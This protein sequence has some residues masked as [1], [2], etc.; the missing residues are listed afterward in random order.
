MSALNLFALTP[1]TPDRPVPIEPPPGA[2]D[3]QDVSLPDGI[4]E[5]LRTFEHDRFLFLERHLARAERSM[6]ALGWEE[7]LQE[8]LVRR[9]LQAA[10]SASPQGDARLRLDLFEQPQEVLG[11]TTRALV[12]LAPFRPVS[13]EVLARGVRVGVARGMAR[14]TPKVKHNEWIYRRRGSGPG[15]AGY[16]E[17]LLLDDQDRIL[18]GSSCNVF[19]VRGGELST[20][21]ADV[22]EGIQRGVFLELAENASIPTCIASQP[23]AEVGEFQEMFLTSSTRAAVPIVEVAGA[24]V[25]DGEPGP[26]W[27]RLLEAYVDLAAEARPAVVVS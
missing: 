13:P 2:R 9:G 3:L 14:H 25:G 15:D 12:T 6:A 19:C 1:S 18:E 11:V 4:Y 5:G 22:L 7:P 26:I 23:L 8:E 17:H 20:A 10:A 27:R 21:G 16:Y 24:P